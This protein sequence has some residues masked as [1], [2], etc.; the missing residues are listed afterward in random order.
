MKVRDIDR[1]VKNSVAWLLA[2]TCT[3]NA[4]KYVSKFNRFGAIVKPTRLG[5]LTYSGNMHTFAKI[6]VCVEPS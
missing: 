4:R 6:G 1:A 2:F 5:R 3:K